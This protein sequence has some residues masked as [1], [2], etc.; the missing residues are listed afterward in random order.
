M[1]SFLK[2]TNMDNF[3][4]AA[5]DISDIENISKWFPKGGVIDINL[6]ERGMVLSLHGQNTCQEHITKIDI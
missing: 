5:L 4:I 6:A 3:T 2:F 1:N